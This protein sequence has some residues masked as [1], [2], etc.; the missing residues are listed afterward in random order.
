MSLAWSRGSVGHVK[1]RSHRVNRRFVGF[2]IHSDL[3]WKTH[4]EFRH[5]ARAMPLDALNSWTRRD[6]AGLRSSRILLKGL[7][8]DARRR[9]S[10]FLLDLGVCSQAVLRTMVKK[11]RPLPTPNPIGLLTYIPLLRSMDAVYRERSTGSRP[12]VPCSAENASLNFQSDPHA[13]Q[14]HSRALF[15]KSLPAQLCSVSEKQPNYSQP[16]KKNIILFSGHVV[17]GVLRSIFYLS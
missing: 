15:G 8:A 10:C 11:P 16:T 6:Q 2:G 4:R 12:S 5:P 14:L 1:R 9:L 13:A 3:K 17:I 7:Q